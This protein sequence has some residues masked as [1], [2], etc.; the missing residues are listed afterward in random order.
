MGICRARMAAEP[1]CAIRVAASPRPAQ[2]HA[3]SISAAQLAHLLYGIDWRPRGWAG[4]NLLAMLLFEKFG[5]HQ[6]LNRQSERYAGEG[7][8]L[9]LSTLADQVGAGCAVL[10]PLL[11]RA[12]AHVFASERLHGDDTTVPVLAKAKTITGRCWV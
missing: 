10:E 9:A 6:P 7:V 12:E 2:E 11:R 5:Q 3:F 8:P 1:A 4:P